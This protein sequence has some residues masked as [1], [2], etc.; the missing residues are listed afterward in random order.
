M[1]EWEATQYELSHNALGID[2]QKSGVRYFI[3]KGRENLILSTKNGELKLTPAEC[4]TICVE[5]P[6][7]LREMGYW[8]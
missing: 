5:L 2:S 8:I 4:K 6:E 7:I 3:P 1:T